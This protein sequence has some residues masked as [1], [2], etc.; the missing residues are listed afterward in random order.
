MEA[1]TSDVNHCQALDEFRRSCRKYYV[2]YAMSSL[3][4]KQGYDFLKSSDANPDNTLY[5]GKGPPS[6]GKS[7][8]DI[9][10]GEY[11]RGYENREFQ[12]L[13]ARSFVI[14]IYTEW[15]EVWRPKI[16]EKSRVNTA[17]V[18]CDLMG[19]LRRIRNFIIHNDWKSELEVLDWVVNPDEFRITEDMLRKLISQIGTMQVTMERRSNP[20]P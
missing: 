5:V 4:L 2:C 13:V 8:A 16:A 17:D 9:R 18:K 14:A 1:R 15:E 3:G 10:I 7:D 6:D 19:D 12:E 20:A 11:F